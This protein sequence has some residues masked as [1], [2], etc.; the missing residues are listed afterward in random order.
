M[1][2]LLEC[3]SPPLT[4][5]E[6]K[7][8]REAIRDV[9]KS[10][11][12][13]RGHARRLFAGLLPLVQMAAAEEAYIPASVFERENNEDEDDEEAGERVAVKGESDDKEPTSSSETTSTMVPDAASTEVLRYLRVC[14]ELV[15]AYLSGLEDR[16]SGVA[17]AAAEE[18]SG[19]R[20]RQQSRRS[21]ANQSEAT[22]VH[23]A[24]DEAFS[25]AVTLHDLLLPL[26]SCGNEGTRAQ[27]AVLALC[28]KLWHG[29]FEDRDNVV[30]QTVPVLVIRSLSAT[31]KRTD[32]QRL[33]A[34]RHAVDLLD[35]DDDEGIDYL[36]GLLLRTASSPLF[37]RESE[38]RKFLA[39]AFTWHVSFVGD[40]HAAM[41]AQIPGAK[42]SVLKAYGEIY[43]KAWKGCCSSSGSSGG[44][45]KEEEE[46]V[47]DD[48]DD[49][50]G[51]RSSTGSTSSVVDVRTTLEENALQDLMH[52]A[53]HAANPA[54]SKSVRTV[55]EVF[56]DAKKSPDVESLLH[57][58]YGP[59]LWR[60]LSSA[61]ARVRVQAAAVL[62]EVFPLR[63]PYCK[64]NA[65]GSGGGVGSSGKKKKGGRR[66]SMGT[67]SSSTEASVAR[68][69]K[70]LRSLLKD[71]VPAV[72]IAGSTAAARILATFWVAVP[73]DDIRSLL[74]REC[75]CSTCCYC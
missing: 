13:H 29:R 60:A 55:L 18:G 73:S 33:C 2:P 46:G 6:Q 61:N 25:I 30:A 62:A 28:E 20:G 50:G 3:T 40:L 24:I 10:R 42:V 7:Q 8:R 21:D 22:K 16:R 34:V 52:A 26:Q 27:S 32:V 11:K 45:L 53:I 41:R 47:N 39:H 74:N 68:C 23:A 58:S 65:S 54:T 48:G 67:S 49:N 17:G 44:G 63:D 36:K 71:D 69:T 5:R 31:A 38:G 59:I 72:R 35:F 75:W 66:S 14:A 37:L 43:F 9:V 57:R 70:A 64:D 1:P 19:S 15:E 4:A 12:F 56:H 51:G